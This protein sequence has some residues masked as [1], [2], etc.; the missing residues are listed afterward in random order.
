[1]KI[2]I[3]NGHGR[4]TPGKLSPDGRFREYAYTRLI[5][6]AVCA[7][8]I[9]RGYDAE[10]L[11]PEEDDV[12][13]KKRVARVNAHCRELGSQNVCLVAIHVNAAGK[14]DRW[15]DATSWCCYTSRGQT[16]GNLLADCLYFA[17]E[18]HLKGHRI[19]K[20]CSDGDPD[21][22]SDIYILRHNACA[23]A[24]SENGFQDSVPS[25]EYLD[26]DEGIRAI[27]A[28]HVEGITNYINNLKPQQQ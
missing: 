7:H 13:L 4:N 20:D 10:M 26:S 1:M 22:E 5:A 8:L 18:Q 9:Y 19:R 2:L 17:A 14:G 21:D 27:V 24:L 15:Y 28:L 23:A 25:L 3:D 12:S 6:R 16:A 11:V